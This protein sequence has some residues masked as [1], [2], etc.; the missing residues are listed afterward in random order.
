MEFPELINRLESYG[1][2]QNR[3]IYRRHG[4]GENLYGVSTANLKQLKKEI[5]QDQALAEQL[6]GT[7]N[8]DAR[9]L[10][11]M[12]ADPKQMQPELLE[13]WVQEDR[14]YPVLDALAALAAKLPD[15]TVWIDEWTSSD[16]EWIGYAGW[17]LLAQVATHDKKYPDDYFAPF[18][19][20]IETTLQTSK[21][22]T[23]HG[24]NNAL[25]AV[26]LR[27]EALE[28]EAVRIAKS[29]GKVVVDHGETD[30]KTPD[31]I[32]YIEKTKA[33]R[34]KSKQ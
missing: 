5:K 28:A 6:W 10:A 16:D 14:S 17:H 25:I 21:N 1:T 19:S 7:G 30:C 15:P 26:G 3:K 8:Y 27:S 34:A 23:K 20:N 4:A 13:K 18:L 29:L 2:E 24:M 12:I 11:T 22:R 9:I 32:A 33:R 31:A